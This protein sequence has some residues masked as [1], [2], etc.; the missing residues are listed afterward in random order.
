MSSN[1][2]LICTVFKIVNLHSSGNY[3]CFCGVIRY[4]TVFF[5]I[6]ARIIHQNAD[7]IN[8]AISPHKLWNLKIKR[9]IITVFILIRKRCSPIR[10]MRDIFIE[11]GC[12]RIQLHLV[13]QDNCFYTLR[14]G[15]YRS[16]IPCDLFFSTDCCDRCRCAFTSFSKTNAVF[17][18]NNIIPHRIGNS[19]IFHCILNAHCQIV[20]N[21]L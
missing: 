7:L 16:R 19:T 9:K 6:F 17:V 1:S 14:V 15:I 5:Q 13:F 2:P 10:V 8:G 12:L 20:K 18:Q 3:F 4:S 11:I 21:I